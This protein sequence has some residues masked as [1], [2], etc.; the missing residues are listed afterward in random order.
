VCQL[1]NFLSESAVLYE[2]ALLQRIDAAPLMASSLLCSPC[3]KGSCSTHN[4]HSD[5]DIPSECRPSNL[6]N[7]N[8]TKKDTPIM[9]IQTENTL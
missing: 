4:K 5:D 2:Q 9:P 6:I 7:S 3:S 1:P 8:L